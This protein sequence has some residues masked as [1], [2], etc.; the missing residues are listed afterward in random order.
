M[1]RTKNST[2]A[3]ALFSL[4]L[5]VACGSP[6]AYYKFQLQKV[7]QGD[8]LSD[9]SA[10]I[11]KPLTFENADF[12]IDWSP[13]PLTFYFR[14]F[15]KSTK[16]LTINFARSYLISPA[17]N[18][19]DPV[20]PGNGAIAKGDDFILVP[21]QVGVDSWIRPGQQKGDNSGG[22]A[23]QLSP[24][25]DGGGFFA[26]AGDLEEVKKAHAGK[27]AQVVLNISQGAK[28][29]TY[30]FALQVADITAE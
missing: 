23:G 7:S 25:F 17:G 26:E 15:N 1:H 13:G 28:A 29:Q 4:V 3:F 19:F 22:I 24:G 16:E 8:S 5:V 6:R 9:V 2:S 27:T 21:P 20:H 11:A 14:I 18:A 10:R 12:K 30:H